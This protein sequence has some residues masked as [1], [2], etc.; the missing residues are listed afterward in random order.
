MAGYFDVYM[1]V[2]ALKMLDS[3]HDIE[4]VVAVYRVFPDVFSYLVP[5]A[6]SSRSAY[7]CEN[8]INLINQN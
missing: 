1:Y 6:G 2:Y 7:F 4:R 5:R 8:S 3:I